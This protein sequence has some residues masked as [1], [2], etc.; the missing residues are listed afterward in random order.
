MLFIC[1]ELISL[2]YHW[3]LG[4]IQTHKFIL[5]LFLQIYTV[6]IIQIATLLH[7]KCVSA[8][9]NIS[10]SRIKPIVQSVRWAFAFVKNYPNPLISNNPILN[11]LAVLIL[12]TS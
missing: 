9:E 1:T 4:A 5:L 2:R 7:E 6:F 8:D 3:P 12:A 10:N 11:S